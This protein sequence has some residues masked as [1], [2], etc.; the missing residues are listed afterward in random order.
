MAKKGRLN[1][2]GGAKGLHMGRSRLGGFQ[3]ES[4][5]AGLRRTTNGD[6]LWRETSGVLKW[7]HSSA[8]EGTSQ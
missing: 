6:G 8:T 2:S 4:I 5:G 3:K 7:A 1:P